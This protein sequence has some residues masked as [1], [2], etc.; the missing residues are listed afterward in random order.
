[1]AFP[2]LLIVNL[3]KCVYYV[4]MYLANVHS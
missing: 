4:Q 2:S 1:M 3:S